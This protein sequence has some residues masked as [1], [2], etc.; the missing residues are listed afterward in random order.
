MFLWVTMGAILLILISRE[1]NSLT[2]MRNQIRSLQW[3]INE[4]FKKT[5]D[6]IY[7]HTSYL[8]KH[9]KSSRVLDD[10]NEMNRKFSVEQGFGN[11][12]HIYKEL[13]SQMSKISLKLITSPEFTQSNEF[14]YLTDKFNICVESTGRLIRS[15]NDIVRVYLNKRS[16]FPAGTVAKALAYRN[17]TV[18]N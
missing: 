2:G 8:N 12:H 13:I 7:Q 9:F 11:K 3:D 18:L 1:L 10:L 17:Y 14:K 15:H 16:T 6:L 4:Q 5:S